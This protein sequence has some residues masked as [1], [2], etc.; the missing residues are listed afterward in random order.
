ML[1]Y[2]IGQRTTPGRVTKL[3]DHRVNAGVPARQAVVMTVSLDDPDTT[4]RG[5]L[6]APAASPLLAGSSTGPVAGPRARM[7][8]CYRSPISA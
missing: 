2:G 1:E 3:P 5:L 8:P 4:R 7:R 6:G